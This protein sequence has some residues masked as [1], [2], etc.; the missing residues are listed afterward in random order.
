VIRQEK[1]TPTRRPLL[2][3]I[4]I[5]PHERRA[6]AGWRLLLHYLL[7]S[8]ITMLLILVLNVLLQF[9]PLA[10]HM[11]DIVGTAIA[12]GIEIAAVVSATWLAR[13]FLD[14]RTFSSL[15]FRFDRHTLTDLAF[16]FAL[17][18][19]LMGLVF[20]FEW[21][22][23]W[24]HIEGWAFDAEASFSSSLGLL[25]ML[26]L[27]IAI[28]FEEEILSRGYHLHNLADGINLTWAVILSA[29]IF[30]GMHLANPHA[31]WAST[32]GIFFAGCFLAYGYLRTRQLWLPIGLHIGWNFFEGPV[33]GFPVSGLDLPHL[34]AQEVQGPQLITGASFGPEAGLVILPAMALGGLLLWVYT[35]RREG[36][37]L[38]RP[39]AISPPSAASRQSD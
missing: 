9:V 3:R 30:A 28:G 4:F 20:A 21:G 22:M 24:L 36:K 6:R 38:G 8:F 17:P 33:L 39:A 32:L 29:A 2:Q 7:I 16:G 12:K 27:C 10:A 19:L 35:R 31:S 15:G 11:P 34:V 25:A 1:P 14:H 23:G 26:G 18:G 13:R 5:S 37:P